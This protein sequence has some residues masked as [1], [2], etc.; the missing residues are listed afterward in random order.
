M[1]LE[2]IRNGITDKQLKK[3]DNEVGKQYVQGYMY[4]RLSKKALDALELDSNPLKL[5][6]KRNLENAAIKEANITKQGQPKAQIQ[7]EVN[8]LKNDPEFE[9]RV[10][11]ETYDALKYGYIS[12]NSPHLIERTGLLPEV[13]ELPDKFGETQKIKTYESSPRLS[14]AW[15]QNMSK[16]LAALRYFPEMTGLGKTYKINQ[17]K[18]KQLETAEATGSQGKYVSL[19][20][21]RQLGIDR[22]EFIKMNKP[23]YKASRRVTGLSA[24]VG[25]SSPLSGVKNLAI[26]IPRN[27]GNMGV[28]NTFRSIGKL[29]D[30]ASYKKARAKGALEYGARSLE[31]EQHALGYKALNM[32]NYFK[33]LNLMTPTEAMNRIVSSQSGQ[34]YFSQSLA[35]LRGEKGMFKLGTTKQRMRRLMN[36]LWKLSDDEV[37][38]LE[39]TK[40]FDSAIVKETYGHIIDKVGHFSHV[41]TQGGTSTVILPLWMNAQEAK[42]FTLFQRMAMSTTIDSYNNYVKPI[43]EFGNYMP[44][45]RAVGAHAVSGGALYWM[46]DHFLGKEKPVGSKES[47]DSLLD[48]ILLNVWR[49]E[50]LGIFGDVVSPYEQSIS[51]PMTDPIV[52]RN[53][54]EASNQLHQVF[55]G[56][57]TAT[58]AIKDF[59][60]KTVVVAN[61]IDVADKIRRGEG[62]GEYYENMKRL[63]V[64]ARQF[65]KERG[66]DMYSPEGMVG[67]R[68]QYY[69]D[70]KESILFKSEED[71][72]KAYWAAYNFIVTDLEGVNP[73]SRPHQRSKD[74]KRA[75]KSVISHFDP[76]NVSD[77]P[78]GTTKSM[79]RQFYEWMTPGNVRMAKSMEKEYQYLVRKYNR[80]IA[81]N[82]YKN[83]YSTYP[84]Y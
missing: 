83:L 37:K 9:L 11:T 32:S 31:L 58:M 59:T 55:G 74:A 50:F 13:M 80:I 19:A 77:N 15:A 40:D 14:D 51:V 64:M 47:Q 34:L 26:G 69:R 1:R 49:S 35:K 20:I 8:R 7:K 53:L 29:V 44:L 30:A 62:K 84:S 21:K 57:K 78:K 46:Y 18:R 52:I 54:M 82:K 81:S 39:T 48:D 42:P 5:M 79:R 36:E 60:R 56:R 12:V 4:R 45:I 72:A 38:F 10:R 25:L 63:S 75:I 73:H 28:I 41:S 68:Q 23:L 33:Y 27:V 22:S 71:V 2:L 65:K 16:Y 66:I 70:L 67:R 43:K 76:I 17:F 24:I 6:V 61:Q 3:Y